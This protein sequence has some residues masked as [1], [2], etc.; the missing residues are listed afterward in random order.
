MHIIKI[1]NKLDMS[2]EFFIKHNMDAA[3]WKLNGF[4]YKNENLVTKLN[5]TKRHPLFR[6]FSYV[7]NTNM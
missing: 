1:D 6:K 5:R 2:H 7:H 4:I 3:E